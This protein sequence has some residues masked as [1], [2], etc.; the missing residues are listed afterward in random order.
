MNIY[1]ARA[2]YANNYIRKKEK[3]YAFPK[4]GIVSAIDR[5]IGNVYMPLHE[6]IYEKTSLKEDDFLE[7]SITDRVE[8]SELINHIV[9]YNKT[10]YTMIAHIYN[11][12][13]FVLKKEQIK[14][15]FYYLSNINRINQRRIK[16][17][18]IVF[19][20]NDGVFL[21]ANSPNEMMKLVDELEKICNS[22]Y[23]EYLYVGGEFL[24]IKDE[25]KGCRVTKKEHKEIMLQ[26]LSYFSDICI[27]NN[28]KYS[29]SGG[30]LLGAVRNGGMI[31]W[32]DDIDVI[33]TRT[34]FNKMLRVFNDDNK[35]FVI[36]C[37]D[38]DKNDK[39]TYARLVDN[40]T[41]ISN[42]KNTFATGDGIFIDCLPID[43]TPNNSL[44]RNI[45]Y[46]YIRFLFR[47]RRSYLESRRERLKKN[48]KIKYHIKIL[49]SKIWDISFWIDLLNK[50]IKKYNFEDSEIVGNL[51]SN[52][53][54]KEFVSRHCFDDYQMI[55]FEGKEYMI[56]SGYEVYLNNLYKNYYKIPK[57]RKGHHLNTIEWK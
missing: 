30:T 19:L 27:K 3:K 52:Y 32:D 40:N 14:E 57:K 48:H 6:L 1:K 22:N 28:I 24:Q 25:L 13:S 53:K 56:C 9:L 42:S 34:E 15:H 23:N 38:K 46:Y 55:K 36:K 2:I 47:M 49:V 51:V 54:K 17:E 5:E 39:Y 43:G 50:Q 21:L 4:L 31:P 29:L 37:F 35:R 45:D 33:L 16:N 41:I 10:S 20:K 18:N 11:R 26:M 8:D 44:I 12:Y 7:F